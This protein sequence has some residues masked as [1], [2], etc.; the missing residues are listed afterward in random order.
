MVHAAPGSGRAQLAAARWFVSGSE[1][2]PAAA[3]WPGRKKVQGIATQR[4]TQRL[5]HRRQA[6]R[7]NA[8][9][10]R[11][12]ATV[13]IKE[14]L[15]T[16]RFD[17]IDPRIETQHCVLGGLQVLRAHA[18]DHVLA[19]PDRIDPRRTQRHAPTIGHDQVQAILRVQASLQHIHRRAAEETGHEQIGWAVVQRHRT[20]DLLDHA[21]LEHHDTLAERHRLD[22]IVGDVDHGGTELA[23]QLRDLG[24]HAVAQLGIQI[25]QR[26][27]EQK[28]TDDSRTIARPSA[29]RCR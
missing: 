9:H 8:D 29:T 6:L 28:N 10:Q 21:I 17:H 3:R 14:D 22:L 25:G 24:A 5:S 19:E 26:L 1:P 16:D 23:V 13:E 2:L 20:I 7:R 15:V 18:N 12:T 4:Q 11:L 27:V